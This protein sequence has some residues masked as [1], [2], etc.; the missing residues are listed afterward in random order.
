MEIVKM[1]FGSHLYGTST[2]DSD[3]DYK[4]IFLPSKEEIYLGKIPKSKQENSKKNNTAKNTSEDTDTEMYSLHYFLKMACD[5]ETATL[6][7][8][9][10]PDNMIINKTNL[11]DE[12]VSQRQRFYTRNLRALIG[13]ARRQASKYGIRGSRLNDAK[14]V[15]DFCKDRNFDQTIIKLRDVWN[16]LPTGEHIFKYKASPENNNIRMYEVCGRKIGETCSIQQLHDIVNNFYLS[17]GHRAEQAAKNEGIDWKAVSHALRA[18]Y[19]IRQILTENTLTF[20]LKEAEF[21]KQVK[22]GQLHFTNEIQPL[23]DKLMIEVEYLSS[24]STLPEKVDRKYW[25]N[26]LIYTLDRFLDR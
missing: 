25:D 11:W 17:Y 3:R 18:A 10:A 22:T 24:K 21:L 13:Y 2:P 8:L 5:G 4:G 7:M 9:H 20:P 16:Y 6:D 14:K 26:F 15:V 12:I 19:Q 23:L 1:I